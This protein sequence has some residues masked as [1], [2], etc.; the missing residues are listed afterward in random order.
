MSPP[1]EETGSLDSAVPD[2]IA[3]RYEVVRA[4]GEDRLGRVFEVRDRQVDG[5]R[6]A[7]KLFWSKFSFVPQFKDVFFRRVKVA[8]S[9][10]GEHVNRVLSSYR[11]KTQRRGAKTRRR[12]GS[13]D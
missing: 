8:Q 12:K 2:V 10:T 4:L 13:N 11:K 5:R 7:L 9:I 6:V 1:P 3:G